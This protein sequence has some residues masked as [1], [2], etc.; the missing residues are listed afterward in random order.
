MSIIKLKSLQEHYK[1]KLTDKKSE[2]V[3]DS[4]K[5]YRTKD[6][7][8]SI[9]TEMIDQAL[10]SIKKQKSQQTRKNTGKLLSGKLNGSHQ[11]T[12]KDKKSFAQ[13]IIGALPAQLV[14]PTGHY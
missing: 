8:V 13:I 14:N 12:I 9:T 7:G 5:M 10:K 11:S 6:P 1:E 4:P 2:Y 3:S